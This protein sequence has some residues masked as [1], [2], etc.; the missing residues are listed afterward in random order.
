ME[1]G[2]ELVQTQCLNCNASLEGAFCHQCSQPVRDNSDRSLGRLLG[3]VFSNFF[4]VDNRFFL[5]MWYLLR[6]PSRMTVEFL[7]GKRKKFI[8]PVTLFLF[9]NLI[10]FLVNPLTDYSIS[11]YDQTHSQAYSDLTKAWVDLKLQKEG[12]SEQAYSITYQNASDNISKSIMIINIPIIAFFV[13]LMAFKRRRFYFDSLIFTFHYFSL[14]MFS[15]VM[16]DWVG[17]LLDLLVGDEDSIVYTIFFML[18]LFVVPL[19]YAILAIK[20]FIGNPW[21][22]AIL[23][24]IG[25]LA[26]VVLTNIFYR[27]IIFILTFWF[28]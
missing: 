16:L 4:F 15:L 21:Y 25:V 11:L 22:W 26:S 13:Y 24:G 27:F 14:F 12:L 23:A 19:F 20:K 5:S 8:P 18:F 7:E 10:Y 3:V 28:T 9:L 2:N 17:S 1:E 6:F